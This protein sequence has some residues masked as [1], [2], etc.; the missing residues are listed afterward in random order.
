ME[1]RSSWQLWRLK[2]SP[3]GSNLSLEIKSN[4]GRSNW[5]LEDSNP[6][7]ETQI[8]PWRLKSS[9]GG[10]NPALTCKKDSQQP[11]E[12]SW[13]FWFKVC[14]LGE[15]GPPEPRTAQNDLP[16]AFWEPFGHQSPEQFKISLQRP[17]ESHVATRA[18][19]G[20]AW[21]WCPSGCQADLSWPQAATF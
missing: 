2:S 1:I 8:Q 16:D 3:G 19:N 12:K 5:P 11:E 7:L 6:A 13:S 15:A 20:T 21:P 17:S 14:R 4:P 10:S 18:Q 9:S